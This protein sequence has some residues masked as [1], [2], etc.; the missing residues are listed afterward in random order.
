VKNE[1]KGKFT[2]YLKSFYF[3]K[4][5]KDET[6]I[7]KTQIFL[8]LQLKVIIKFYLTFSERFVGDLLAFVFLFS[9]FLAYPLSFPRTQS[10]SCF[11]FV[12]VRSRLVGRKF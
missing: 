8:L 4:L 2:E 12:E 10:F 5:M 11:A 6:R 9:L 1:F 3:Y 7:K